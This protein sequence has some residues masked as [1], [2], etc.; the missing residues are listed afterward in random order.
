[1]KKSNEKIT[2]N[3]SSSSLASDVNSE[4]GTTPPVISDKFEK[5]MIPVEEFRAMV[6]AH[7]VQ[8]Q[9]IQS[10]EK[11]LAEL[12]EIKKQVK[13]L[14]DQYSAS[15]QPTS[16]A[17]VVAETRVLS[18]V[19]VADLLLV[20]GLVGSVGSRSPLGF[21]LCLSLAALGGSM[22]LFTP[23]YQAR[24]ANPPRPEEPALD[25]DSRLWNLVLSRPW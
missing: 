11:G 2:S 3:V 13:K 8:D 4:G 12:E 24:T 5:V 18:R 6:A 19:S 25:D 10:L 9:R 21:R 14:V 20:A 16:E 1:M 7:S 17:P 23:S 22:R 15:S